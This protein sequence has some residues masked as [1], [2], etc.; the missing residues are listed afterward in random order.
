MTRLFS[1]YRPHYRQTLRLGAP[2]MLGQLG[3]IVVGF[4]DNIMVG[5]HS[6]AELAAASFVNN[7][8]TLAFISGIG[9]SYGL[10]PLVGELLAAGKKRATGELLKNSLL[11]N[12]AIGLLLTGAMTF[13]LLHLDLLRQ[14]PELMPYIVPYYILQLCSIPFTML[15]NA[16]KQFSDGSMDTKTPMWIML[17]ANVLNIAGNYFLIYGNYGVP[18]LGLTG[19]GISTLAS[20]VI[21]LG[22]FAGLFFRAKKYRAY[23][24]GFLHGSFRRRTVERLV[25]MGLPVGIQMGVETASFSLSV[26][27]M[28]WLGSIALAAHQIVGVV[29]TLGFMV[30]YGIA[31]AVAIRVS[32]F[33][34]KK[35]RIE[36]RHASFAGL[37]LIWATAF[38]VVGLVFVSRHRIG[39]LFTAEEE[40]AA[41]VAVLSFPVMLYQFGDG[42]Q[43]LFSNALRGIRDVNYMAVAAF[44]CHFFLS[45]PVGYF[46]GFVLKW[47]ALG[48]WCGFPVSLSVLGLVLYARFNRLTRQGSRNSFP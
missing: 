45:L 23:R 13:L 17:G 25:K 48:V 3:I 1:L 11:V 6:T 28:G 5:H 30:Y 43:I 40:V 24:I 31:A 29:T 46:C 44:L 22:A 42:L 19:A 16:F 37:H 32:Y 4:A 7:F 39:Y 14:P 9:F 36:V 12:G 47:G 15:F 41:L 2:I 34:G 10:T 35:E 8:F 26:I 27:M 20:R 21:I 18:E 38:L 33:C